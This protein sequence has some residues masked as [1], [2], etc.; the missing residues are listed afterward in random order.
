[1]NVSCRFFSEPDEIALDRER[2]LAVYRICQEALNNIAKYAKATSVSVEVN[3]S[4]TVLSLRIRDNGRGFE[5][6]AL[7]KKNCFGIR[8]MRERALSLGGRLDVAGEPGHG[9]CVELTL[10]LHA[11]AAE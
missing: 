8:G 9:V 7:D 4:A 11:M 2:T 10:P 1:M 6:A 5:P 3:A